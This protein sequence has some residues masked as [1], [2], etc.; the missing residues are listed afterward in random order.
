[1]LSDQ[2]PEPELAQQC[3]DSLAM[4]L[5]MSDA[6]LA[7]VGRPDSRE[8]RKLK[9]R[10]LNANTQVRHFLASLNGEVFKPPKTDKW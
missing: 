10:M 2:I 3:L 1:M 8:G 4:F 5:T 6:W 9:N 7:R